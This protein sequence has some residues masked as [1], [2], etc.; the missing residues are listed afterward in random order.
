MLDLL[1]TTASESHYKSVV[2]A[3]WYALDAGGG[4]RA[5]S[6]SQARL[7]RRR[8]GSRLLRCKRGGLLASGRTKAVKAKAWG[9]P[10]T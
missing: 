5:A 4:P 3:I 7:R 1:V 10:A 6:C 2:E 8:E 9:W